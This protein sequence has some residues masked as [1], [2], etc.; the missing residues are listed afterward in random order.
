MLSVYEDGDLVGSDEA[1]PA[2]VLAAAP[3]VTGC[4]CWTRRCCYHPSPCVLNDRVFRVGVPWIAG[5]AN[6]R[7]YF[8]V[9]V[10]RLED[11]SLFQSRQQSIDGGLRRL[12]RRVWQDHRELVA[13]DS[14]GQVAGSRLVKEKLSERLQDEIADPVAV[15]AVDLVHAVDVYHEDGERALESPGVLKLALKTLEEVSPIKEMGQGVA[16]GL[17]LQLHV[18]HDQSKTK[19]LFKLDRVAPRVKA[20]EDGVGAKPDEDKRIGEEP[21]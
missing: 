9:H 7:R 10:V 13:A 8:D 21:G 5:G 11:R 17:A 20:S 19:L 14:S 3:L 6:R 18:P 2:P 4:I 12:L 1:A 15:G 16:C